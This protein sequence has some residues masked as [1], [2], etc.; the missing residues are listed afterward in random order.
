MKI[1][2]ILFDTCP[3][4]KEIENCFKDKDL[5][6]ADYI[7]NSFTTT[8]LVSLFTGK[9]PS[10]MHRGGIGYHGT[11]K[12]FV[13]KENW[14]AK[15]LFNKLPED[16]NIHLHGD[17]DN[18]K[19]VTEE[20]CGIDREYS[21]YIYDVGV[22]ENE[23]LQQ[24][25]DLPHDQN[26]FIFIKYNH[27][28]DVAAT[29]SGH[30][31]A[32]K[33]FI[34]TINSIDFTE[35]N[36]MF[37]LFSDHG[38]PHK[39]D[40]LMSPPDAW[41]SWVSVTDNITNEDVDKDL[42]YVCDFHDTVLNR[43]L[44]TELSSVDVLSP[45]DPNQIY[46]VEDGRASADINYCTTVSAITQILCGVFKQF[47]HYRLSNQSRTVLYETGTGNMMQVEE[48]TKLIDHLKN[49]VWGDWYMGIG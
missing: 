24:M 43:V 17:K 33:F 29:G 7:T 48:D 14:N 23:F 1:Y 38:I 12:Y 25:R 42:I 8:S 44:G 28:H 34:D 27:Y 15:F 6:Y 49:G 9:T 22:N 47:S 19:F 32:V 16:W 10:E 45:L 21:S 30:D 3:R 18:Y 4:L 26:H 37:W 2:C 31:T 46:V 41:L 5:H 39:V 36:S 13:D 20:C 11:Y 35:E 40:H